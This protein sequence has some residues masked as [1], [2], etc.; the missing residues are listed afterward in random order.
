METIAFILQNHQTKT[1]AT[2]HKHSV[3]INRFLPFLLFCFFF[4]IYGCSTS[5]QSGNTGPYAAISVYALSPDAPQLNVFINDANTAT[6]LPFGSFT[7]YNPVTPGNASIT[8]QTASQHVV[9]T[10]NFTTIAGNYYSLF[11][12]DTF[13][14]I[15]PVYVQD[16]LGTATDTLY[17]RFFNF[18]PDAPAVD[19]YSY[20]DSSNHTTLWKNRSINNDVT[21]DSINKF[22]GSKLGTYFFYA[23]R[24][25]S[26][27]T[28]AKFTGNNLIN[29]GYY[30][31][32]LEGKFRAITDSSTY[33]TTLQLSIRPH[34]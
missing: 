21:N 30:T 29:A 10:T 24:S 2:A 6:S 5:K 16:N 14:K 4:S 20:S 11:F 18:S 12:I 3:M 32:L 15:N 31:L 28:L 1:N 17:L 8:A 22:V 26:T 19:I 23:I 27:D 33:D 9:V 25:G 7:I 13:S 34:L